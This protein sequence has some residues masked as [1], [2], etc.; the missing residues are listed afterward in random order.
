MAPKTNVWGMAPKAKAMKAKGPKRAAGAAT[1]K[2][3]ERDIDAENDSAPSKKT[4]ARKRPAASWHATAAY[5]ASE[6]EPNIALL[7]DAGEDVNDGQ[8]DLRPTTRGQR[9]VFEKLANQIDPIVLARYEYLKDP[10]N[11]VPGKERECRA[12]INAH[13]SRNATYK[14]D[15]LSVKSRTMEQVLEKKTSPAT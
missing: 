11:K 9:Y 1:A 12:M 10:R 7:A 5:D 15:A 2:H 13:V 14:T 3:N 8:Q 4:A 6:Q